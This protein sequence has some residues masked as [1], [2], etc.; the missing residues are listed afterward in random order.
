M[1][2]EEILAIASRPEVPKFFF[3]SPELD[4]WTRQH[5]D[6]YTGV[7]KQDSGVYVVHHRSLQPQQPD[8][9]V[10]SRW[11]VGTPTPMAWDVPTQLH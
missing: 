11:L 5:R 4:E 1:S 2:P 6:A 9:Q 8:F 3:G 7:A 10:L